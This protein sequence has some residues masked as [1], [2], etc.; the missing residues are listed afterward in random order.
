M[1]WLHLMAGYWLSAGVKKRFRNNFSSMRQLWFKKW[2]WIYRPTGLVGWILCALVLAAIV[3][4]F[5]V[6]DRNS[7]SASDTLIGVFPWAWIAIATLGWIAS[8]TRE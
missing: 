7:H 3:W 8:K 2:G 6:V 1:E 5:V 4:V